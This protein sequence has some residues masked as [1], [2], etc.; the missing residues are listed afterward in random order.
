[1]KEVTLNGRIYYTWISEG[2]TFY[3]SKESYDFFNTFFKAGEDK[4]LE[5]SRMI[6]LDDEKIKNNC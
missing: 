6:F 1:M 2:V 4:P 5:S 3:T